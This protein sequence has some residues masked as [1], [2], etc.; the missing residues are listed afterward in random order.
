MSIV[1]RG[2]ERADVLVFSPP[3]FER[4]LEI[5]GPVTVRLW[6]AFDSPDTD[7]TAKPIDVHRPND[8]NPN[9]GEPEGDM[10]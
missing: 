2:T 10:E 3:P 1:R 7:F 8:I 6:I 5:T 4:N 9:S